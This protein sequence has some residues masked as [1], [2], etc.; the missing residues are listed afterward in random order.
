[1]MG[2]R[3]TLVF[4]NSPTPSNFHKELFLYRHYDGY[5]E[6]TMYDLLAL[7]SLEGYNRAF[8]NPQ[9][10]RGLS[11]LRMLQN[12][13]HSLRTRLIGLSSARKFCSQRNFKSAYRESE[14]V[15]GDSEFL[16]I[17]TMK[18]STV[19]PANN[20]LITIDLLRKKQW[21]SKVWDRVCSL[22]LPYDHDA[23]RKEPAV[24]Y[25]EQN[26]GKNFGFDSAKDNYRFIPESWQNIWNEVK[27]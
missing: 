14:G 18:E 17:V 26:Y 12:T 24:H 20:A 7:V 13:P 1:M 15:S 8:N 21:D 5:P 3:A 10:T 9:R 22:E 27:E 16:Y 4:K 2:T 23:L 19:E 6:E 25:V 11:S